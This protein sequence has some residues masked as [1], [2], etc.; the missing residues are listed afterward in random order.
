MNYYID[1]AYDDLINREKELLKIGT[2][3]LNVRS[4]D[5]LIEYNVDIKEIGY[6]IFKD[7]GN[8]NYL[9]IINFQHFKA[10]TL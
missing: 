7:Q 1:V 5:Q 8:F 6:D 10:I 4:S 2:C 3:Y 9:I